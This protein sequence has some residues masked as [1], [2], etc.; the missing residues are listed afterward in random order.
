MS[1]DNTSETRNTN[2]KHSRLVLSIW[3]FRRGGDFAW[4][5]QVIRNT[6]SLLV[7]NPCARGYMEWLG[8]F[9][10]CAGEE[11]KA[12]LGKPDFVF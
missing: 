3:C 10:I 9:V 12:V 6:R 7:K 5:C 1:T 11:G 4:G 8:Q 2:K